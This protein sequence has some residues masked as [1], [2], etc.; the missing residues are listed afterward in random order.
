M[1]REVNRKIITRD[2]GRIMKKKKH[3]QIRFM[4]TAIL[5]M[6]ALFTYMLILVTNIQGNARVINYTGIIRGATQ[7]LVKNELYDIEED[8]EIH[9]LDQILTG[10]KTG[11]SEFEIKAL[12]DKLF[13]SR[14][15]NLMVKWDELKV[16]ITAAR[17]DARIKYRLHEDSEIYFHLANDTVYAAERYTQKLTQKLKY[18]EV[19]IF[20]NI[21]LILLSLVFQIA[22]EVKENRK[23]KSI[24]FTDP[25]TSLPNKRSC[26]MK[27][28]QKY[29]SDAQS[30]CCF[31]FDLNC[32][33]AVNDSLGHASGDLL[34]KS[35]ADLLRQ[36]APPEMFVGRL[37]GDEFIGICEDMTHKEISDFLNRLKE[38]TCHLNRTQ[39]RSGMMLSFSAGY[40]TSLNYPHLS[41]RE[42]MEFAD[43]EMYKNKAV[44]KRAKE[45]TIV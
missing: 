27:L 22:G 19:L 25:N 32:L 10:L 31:M 26:E 15:S 16:I 44:F 17:A 12:D 42:L 5:V 30:V 8:E 11:E 4:T 2:D 9:R 38:E 29:D 35:F 1:D 13:Q 24:A 40:A 36:C 41:I 43:S 45:K 21:S 3:Q 14:L 20:I 23:L 18:M 37:G 34:I 33:K 28:S 39:M 7:R 6:I